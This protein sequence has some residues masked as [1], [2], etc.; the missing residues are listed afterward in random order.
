MTNIILKTQINNN[1]LHKKPS[2]N[3][4]KLK[5]NENRSIMQERFPFLI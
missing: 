3:Y 5:V 4:R 2:N 1:K